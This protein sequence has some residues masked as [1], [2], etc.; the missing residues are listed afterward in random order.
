MS[1]AGVRRHEVMVQLDLMLRLVF[2]SG[3]CCANGFAITSGSACAGALR[4]QEGSATEQSLTRPS[5]WLGMGRGRR[6][7]DKCLPLPQKPKSQV[8]R[9][10]AA[11]RVPR[12]SSRVFIERFLAEGE[13]VQKRGVQEIVR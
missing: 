12:L 2:D 4:F 10:R 6:F 13:R 3:Y 7:S 11:G 8:A 9:P 5:R 1:A